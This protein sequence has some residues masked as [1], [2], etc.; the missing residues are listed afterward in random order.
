MIYIWELPIEP[1]FRRLIFINKLNRII[2]A[3]TT[4]FYI[5]LGRNNAKRYLPFS[6]SY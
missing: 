1:N 3:S 5:A 2:K 4:Y 6:L